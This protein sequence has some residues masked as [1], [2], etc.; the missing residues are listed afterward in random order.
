[1]SGMQRPS[2]DVLSFLA[3]PGRPASV[4][5]VTG[6][7]QPALAMMWFT[8]EDG[9]VWF[10]SPT[11]EPAPFLRAAGQGEPVAVM[12]ATFSPPDDVRQVRMTGPARLRAG[13]EARV[14][15][16]Y[17]RYVPEW[18]PDWEQQ[19]TSE[20]YCL[21]SMSPDRGMAV[22]YPGLA[23]GPP[24]YWSGPAEFE[25]LRSGSG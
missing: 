10:H 2:F 17:D 19:A 9:Q 14:R 25:A 13:D 7:G 6:R 16:I 4:A 5:T 23:G 20:D 21:W 15:R 24:F 18:T 3:E 8:V 22:A 11:D 12:V 1:M